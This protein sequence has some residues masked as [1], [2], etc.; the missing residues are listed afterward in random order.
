MGSDNAARAP[1]AERIRW[2]PR[3]RREKLRRLYESEARGILDAELLDDVGTTI[4]CRCRDILIVSDAAEGRVVCPRC[5]RAVPRAG[6]DD[7]EQMIECES[8]GWAMRWREFRRS[9]QHQELYA[10]GVADA[11]VEFMRG[12]ERAASA[13][14]KMTLID[15][16]IHVWHWETSRDHEKG[17]PAAVNLIEGNRRQV[18]AFLDELSGREHESHADRRR[19]S[20]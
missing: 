11:I 16:L 14:E 3:V 19:P 2:A 15:R 10:R 12:W 18:L 17:R 4:Y 5:A 7:P 13:R 20:R 9:Y 8:C 6:G 1:R